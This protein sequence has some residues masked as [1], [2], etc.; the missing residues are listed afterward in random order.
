MYHHA[1]YE[2]ISSVLE[3]EKE[4]E[5]HHQQQQQQQQRRRSFA[6][7][8]WF[9]FLVVVWIACIVFGL[10]TLC[11]YVR[12]IGINKLEYW[13]LSR[14]GLYHKERWD[15]NL[16]L[17]L[18]FISASYIML[19][20]TFQYV[21]WIRRKYQYRFHRWNGRILL[22]AS[23]VGAMGGMYYIGAVGVSFEPRRL[24]NVMNMLFGISVIV[25]AL[26][27]YYCAAW[28][29]DYDQHKL[30]AYRF[31]GIFMGNI[32]VRMCTV[33]FRVVMGSLPLWGS[34]ILQYIFFIPFILLA[35]KVWTSEHNINSND[36]HEEKAAI[37]SRLFLVL[38]ALGLAWLV[39]ALIVESLLTW[40]PLMITDLTP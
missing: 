14:P 9:C 32:F 38:A 12:A 31:S 3:E 2:S 22:L 11:F 19:L 33:T 28:K 27:M 6:S 18:H 24:A 26:N 21:P 10:Y 15:S 8:L 13:D 30:W 5:N 29:R 20:G 4:T 1:S 23:L 35:Q 40:I 34:I 16:G 36:I 39:V 37:P 17:S 7:W 25:C